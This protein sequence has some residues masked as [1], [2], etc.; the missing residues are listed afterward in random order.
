MLGH[1]MCCRGC[2]LGDAWCGQ[3]FNI[4][5]ELASAEEITQLFDLVNASDA[6]VCLRLGVWLSKW[7]V[8]TYGDVSV[9][10]DVA[11]VVDFFPATAPTTTTTS[12]MRR[13]LQSYLYA[14]ESFMALCKLL[15]PTRCL[16]VPTVTSRASVA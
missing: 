10:G 5:P 12:W 8:S 13:S 11:T 1:L 15:A 16:W 3:Q 14:S 4:T 2:T 7:G 6:Y 9:S